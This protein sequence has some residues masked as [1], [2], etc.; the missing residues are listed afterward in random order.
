MQDTS[1]SLDDLT[2]DRVTT[3]FDLPGHTTVRALGVA[4]GIVVR[5]RSIV[6][7]FGAA[8]QTLF[9]G[10]ITL[11]TSLCEKARQQA[12]DK[13]LADARTLGANAVVAMRYDSTEIGTGVTEVICYGTAVRVG[14]DR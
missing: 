12:F 2:P 13:M 8:L 7:S 10:N 1:R 14:H 3:A 5:S 9:G 11:Y 6:G 4:Q